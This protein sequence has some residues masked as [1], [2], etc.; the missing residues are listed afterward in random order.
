MIHT[1]SQHAG[2]TTNGQVGVIGCSEPIHF[3]HEKSA[4]TLGTEGNKS[5][6]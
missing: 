3:E 5:V 1:Y 4:M 6:A 2:P